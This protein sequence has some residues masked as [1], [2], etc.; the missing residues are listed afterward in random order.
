MTSD[1]SWLDLEERLVVVS[2]GF[3]VYL[4]LKVALT[5]LV[6]QTAAR[7]H[8]LGQ[9]GQDREGKWIWKIFY[10]GELERSS[11]T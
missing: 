11:L 10:P 2:L 9:L 4:G 1:L 8:V 3:E 5:G 7:L 6:G